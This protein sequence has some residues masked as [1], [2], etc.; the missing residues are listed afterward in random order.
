MG[1]FL[2]SC[3]DLL[4]PS[5]CQVQA[6]SVTAGEL[7]TTPFELYLLNPSHSSPTQL[8]LAIPHK[9][10]QIRHLSLTLI[11]VSHYTENVN[12]TLEIGILKIQV[13]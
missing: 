9:A 6:T 1:Q 13:T 11:P 7:I 5:S 3:V 10:S 8:L 2:P 4:P 12:T